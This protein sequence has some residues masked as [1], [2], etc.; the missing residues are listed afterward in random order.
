VKTRD[1]RAEIKG[2]EI[3]GLLDVGIAIFRTLNVVSG[4]WYGRK[5][6]EKSQLFL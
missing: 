3:F 5:I 2:E 1:T 4:A 6:L